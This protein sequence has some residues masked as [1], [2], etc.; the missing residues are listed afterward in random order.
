MASV[1]W[2]PQPLVQH[3]SWCCLHFIDN[4][5]GRDF[6]IAVQLETLR[7]RLQ[8][9]EFQHVVG[10]ELALG[11]PL[12]DILKELGPEVSVPLINL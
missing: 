5:L 2:Y 9:V 8:S 7:D 6:P 4:L 1:L 3:G 10:L 11:D 12:R